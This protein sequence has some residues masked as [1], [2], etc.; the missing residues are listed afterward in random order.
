ME[1]DIITASQATWLDIAKYTA[2]CL[3]PILITTIATLL[4]KITKAN[5]IASASSKIAS[6]EAVIEYEYAHYQGSQKMNR[7]LMAAQHYLTD[8]E[9]KAIGGNENIKAQAQYIFDN[10]LKP[11]ITEDKR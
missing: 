5:H 10:S 4:K 6:L 8:D 1:I 2:I 7:L 3:V 9:I 11:L